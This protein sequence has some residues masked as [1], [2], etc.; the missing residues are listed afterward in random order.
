M[1]IL[2]LKNITTMKKTLLKKVFTLVLSILTT[3][4]VYAQGTYGGNLYFD[5]KNSDATWT[6]STTG[7]FTISSFGTANTNIIVGA[8]SSVSPTRSAKEGYSGATKCRTVE[9]SELP[10]L[11]YIGL[12][13]QNG[14]SSNQAVLEVQVYTGSAWL[15]TETLT[16]AGNAATTWKPTSVLS[17]SGVKV[18]FVFPFDCW[19]YGLKTYDLKNAETYQDAPSLLFTTPAE[20]ANLPANGTISLQFDELLKV[21]TGTPTLGNATINSVTYLGNVMVISYSGY[22]D[23]TNPLFVPSVCV[24]DYSGTSLS[25]DITKNFAI[26]ITP[27]NYVSASIP[28]GST[29]HIQDLG[30]T[31]RKIKLTFDEDI[32]VGTGTISFNGVTVSTSISGK[33]LTISYFGLPYNATNTLTVPASFIKDLSGNILATDVVLT[34][35]TGARDATPPV[36]NAQSVINGAVNQP[37]GGS[38]YLTFDEVVTGTTIPITIDGVPVTVSNNNNVLGL[39]YNNLPYNTDIVVNLPEGSVIDSCGN[40]YAGS[41]FSFTTIAKVPKAFDIIVAK[42]GSGDYTSIQAAINAV[43]SNGTSRT[44]I[45]VKK[46]TYNEKISILAGKNKISLIGEDADNTIITWNECANIATDANG[47]SSPGTDNS[48]TMLVAGTDFYAEN[49][50]IRN[51]YIYL[52]PPAVNEQAV[53]LEHKGDKHVLKN[54]KLYSYQDTYYPKTADTRQYLYNCYIQGGTDFIFGGGTCFIESSI[55]KCIEGGQYITAA[56]EAT[57]EF[58]LV[59]NN[60]TVSYA[61]PSYTMGTKRAFYLGR[62]W[63]TPAKTAYINCKF[64][65]NLVQAVGWAEWSGTNN[66]LSAVYR[67]YNSSNLAGTPLSTANRVAWSKQLSIEQANRHIHDN[68]FN[69]GAN[70]SWN[71]MPYLTAP[72]APENVKKDASGQLSWDESTFA[73]G[74]LVYKNGELLGKTSTNAYTDV[75]Y[76]AESVYTVKAANEYGA[77]STTSES[78]TETGIK[79]TII[80]QG[81]LVSTSITNEIQL[82]DADILVDLVILSPNGQI[83]KSQ[84]V[85]TSTVNISLLLNGLYIAKATT[86]NGSIVIDKFIKK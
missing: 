33:I 59:L 41:S 22:T 64:E 72:T 73:V 71:P 31:V 16:L 20:G 67:E 58:G 10:N 3:L 50:T 37:I 17:K 55:I 68:A 27:P 43:P 86:I 53:A 4:G 42:D 36:L 52:G 21:S 15:T 51:D 44:S 77:L 46:G 85:T 70:G 28:N 63:K 40:A 62:P 2:K 23:A 14:S 39:N 76:E 54:C 12:A 32:Q 11:G 65:D 38:I 7:T 5:F 26:D 60:C 84:K 47:N 79:A 24:T 69:Y 82:K 75:N 57:K 25:G 18:K 74:Y 66:H 8:I 34:Y 19:F 9:L 45:Y 61:D 48:Y 6:T 1:C 29:I 35:Y 56:S 78:A 83:V 81:L 13:V 80:K 49:L 30:E